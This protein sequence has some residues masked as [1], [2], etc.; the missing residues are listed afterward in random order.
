[1]HQ[2][3]F[4]RMEWFVNTWLANAGHQPAEKISVID[5]GSY[6]VNGSYLPLFPESRFRYTGLDMEPGPNVDIVPQKTYDW[7]EIP[8][9]A[10]DV[11]IS[12]QALEHI[13]FF[14]VTFS[15]MVRILKPDG[16]MCLIAPRDHERHR[17]PIDAYRY[18]ADGFA[19]LAKY[20][21][22]TPLHIST[23]EAPAG[24]PKEWFSTSGDTLLV[25][26]KPLSWS[27]MLDIKAYAYEE[28]SM[29]ALRTGF[30]TA[31]Q[32]P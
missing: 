12:G 17:Y 16:L 20:G 11:V 25:A 9:N 23:N 3:S 2:S 6:D 21:N 13:E 8:N 1:M 31:D 10:Y 30:L 32:H 19:A 18:D 7:R 4:L 27:G 22:L 14:W 15:E 24:A 26:R 5:I 29:E 28:W